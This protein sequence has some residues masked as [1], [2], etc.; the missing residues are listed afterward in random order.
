[1]TTVNVVLVLVFLAVWVDSWHFLP[2]I[3]SVSTLSNPIERN[4]KGAILK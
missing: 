2:H 3:S 1:M 4:G